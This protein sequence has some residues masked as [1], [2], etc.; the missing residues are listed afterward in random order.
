[1]DKRKTKGVNATA[2]GKTSTKTVDRN[3]E[4]MDEIEVMNEREKDKKRTI[5]LILSIFTIL[6][7]L[8]GASFAYFTSIVNNI[9]GNQ[10]FTLSGTEL[11]GLTYKYSDTL[12][13]PDAKP[14]D[15]VENTFTVTNPNAGARV[16]YSMKVVSDINNFTAEEGMGQL[17][18]TISGG[19]LKN[20]VVLDFTD[21]EAQKELNVFSKMDLSPKESDV[22]TIKMEFVDI[23]KLQDTNMNKTFVGHIEISQSIV[24]SE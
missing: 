16:R 12:S 23:G 5:I 3:K 1:M 14:G 2:K 13:L 10:S 9:K 17:L 20:P 19:D 6:I 8:V 7:A 15:K 11:E 22:F 21:G 4:I 18:I 24:V